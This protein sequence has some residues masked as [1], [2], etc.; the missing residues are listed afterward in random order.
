MKR[1]KVSL[2]VNGVSYVL[3]AKVNSTLVDLLRDEIGL[4]GTKLGCGEGE[5][6]VQGGIPHYC[7]SFSPVEGWGI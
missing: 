5:C 3:D 7:K 2:K 6:F 1:K 4:L